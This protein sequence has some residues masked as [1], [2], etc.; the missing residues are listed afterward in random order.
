MTQCSVFYCC[1]NT[2]NFMVLNSL[3]WDRF[4]LC[5][6]F[7]STVLLGTKNLSCKRIANV[8]EHSIG[9]ICSEVRLRMMIYMK[10]V[11]LWWDC[12]WLILGSCFEIQLN[13]FN[14]QVQWGLYVYYKDNF[15]FLGCFNIL[16]LWLMACCF[17]DTLLALP[18]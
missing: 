6:C 8:M 9:W 2:N 10:Y 13:N 3:V 7:I 11:Q 12:V 1:L 17:N 14:L 4:V 5:I 15:K 18:L 16:L